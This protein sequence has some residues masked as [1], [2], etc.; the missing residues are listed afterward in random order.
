MHS[1]MYCDSRFA[2]HGCMELLIEPRKRR[3]SSDEIS[4]ACD[5]GA[6]WCI[7]RCNV[8]VHSLRYS[9]YSYKIDEARYDISA[10]RMNPRR[11]LR[12]SAWG[13]SRL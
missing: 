2:L 8:W 11:F 5:I 12:V 7:M 1:E 9:V 13:N 6:I 4:L 10:H 3:A